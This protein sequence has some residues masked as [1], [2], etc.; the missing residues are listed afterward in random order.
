M[1]TG[2][3][4]MYLGTMNCWTAIGFDSL[5]RVENDY[6]GRLGCDHMKKVNC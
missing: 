3:V 4:S 6:S 5:R 2:N 1:R